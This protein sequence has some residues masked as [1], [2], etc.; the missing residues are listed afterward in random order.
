MIKK[1]FRLIKIPV[2]LGFSM[3][4]CLNW[5][6]AQDPSNDYKRYHTPDEINSMLGKLNKDFPGKTALTQ[7]AVS[8]AGKKVML[9][10]IGPDAGKSAKTVPAILVVG[11]VEGDV[12]I[13]SEA[14]IYL[15]DLILN[16]AEVRPD[17]TWYIIPTLNP[18][19]IMHY[20]NKPLKRDTRNG[21]PYN[22]D[23]DDRVDEDGFNDLDGNGIITQMRVKDPL[24]VWIPIPGEPRLM[25]R[26]DNKKGEKGIYKLYTE[27][28]DDDGDG[29]YNEDGPG[30][31]NIGVTFPHLFKTYSITSG[32]WPGS[33]S[34]TFAMMKFTFEHP[35][36]AM[37]FTFGSTN[38][39]MVA[40]KGGR[41]GTADMEN[42]KIPERYATM[43]NADP[44]KSYSIEEIMEMVK[45]MMPPGME[46]TESM[47]ASFLGLGAV[48]NPLREDLTFYNE[49][50]ENYKEFLKEKNA[51][52]KRLS[53]QSAKDGSFEL[54]SYYHLGVPAFT[55]DLWT[56]PEVK[57]E[58]KEE[59][60]LSV[61]KIEGMTNE[62][63]IELGEEK[64]TAFL[65]ESGAPAQYNGAMVI[66]MVKSGQLDT[67]QI[68]GMMKQ[69]GGGDEKK[70]TEGA[71]PKEKALLAFNDEIL[72]GKGYVDWKEFDHPTLGKVEI[73]GAVPYVNNTPP[74]FMID[75]LLNLQVPWVFTLATK[76]PDLK[77]LKTETKSVGSGVHELDVW[78]EN[79]SY[80]PFPTAMGGR[81]QQPAPAILVIKGDLKFLSGKPRTTVG[82][83]EGNKS[84]KLS[85]IVQAESIEDVT[86]TI[87]SK[88]VWGDQKQIKI[89]GT[90]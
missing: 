33:E 77:I 52:P 10:E 60:G 86:L 76:L 20:F 88:N 31:V 74:E 24:G 49:L 28:L 16:G 23:M 4:L 83:I 80:L 72:K 89:G 59:S 3:L 63:F 22:D 17:L 26:A 64:L 8:P 81:N 82:K 87:E 19:G 7:L 44:D 56:L 11:N 85:W 61:D 43:F 6:S 62:E 18:D 47:I 66:N 21:K 79:D 68:A 73:G 78:I 58:E 37:T 45:P 50:S 90:K 2:A 14:A 5:L 75:S 35:E 29:Q 57:K 9:L 67:K 41:T 40:P 39:C 65:K 12:P 48:V 13:S 42:I 1:I 36:I 46:V 32:V 30:G 38:F 54:W 51:E 53:P 34:E 15:A 25:K 69:M 55:M 71:D 27:G 70:D 84:T